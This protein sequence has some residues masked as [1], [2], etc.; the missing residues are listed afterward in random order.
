MIQL[1]AFSQQDRFAKIGGQE[2][3]LRKDEL[4]EPLPPVLP[5]KLLRSGNPPMAV[6]PFVMAHESKEMLYAELDSMRK[7]YAPFMENHA[8][9]KE[10]MRKR[11]PISTMQWR[12]ETAE[13]KK[14][15]SHPASGAGV[16][17]TVKIPHYGPP[18]GHA[19]TFYQQEIVLDD[20]ML[21]RGILFVCFKGVD[22][23]TE[24]Y[25]NGTYSI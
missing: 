16:W 20:E 17:E 18:L 6:L 24:V 21:R 5:N 9:L 11:F 22:Y 13:D 12:K 25:F 4:I 15:I 7:A 3:K 19:V 14:N 1:V 23:K 2:Y 10:S 8:V